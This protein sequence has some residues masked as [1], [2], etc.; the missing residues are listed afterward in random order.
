[1]NSWPEHELANGWN[2]ACQLRAAL[3]SGYSAPQLQPIG[4]RLFPQEQLHA[5]A[6]L[7]HEI[8]CGM[9]VSYSQSTTAFGGPL[10]FATGL[11]VSAAGNARR[12]R[13]AE[14]MAAEQWR[15][16]GFCRTVLTNHRILAF[17]GNQWVSWDHGSIMELLPAPQQFTITV[18]F[19]GIEPLR[20]TGPGAPWLGVILAFLLFGPAYLADHP[21][22][23]PMNMPVPQTDYYVT[24]EYPERPG[25]MPCLER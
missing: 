1:M 7:R 25:P 15:F 6:P 24:R 11:L 23:R 18:A 21:G 22:F 19:N 13:Q 14:R 5:V 20:L 16:Q 10:M 2:G 9:D 3:L 12:R 4:L 8:W 17:S